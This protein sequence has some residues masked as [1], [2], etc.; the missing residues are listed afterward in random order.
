M[1]QRTSAVFLMH[2]VQDVNV[3]RPLI[4]MAA[5]DFAFDTLMLVSAGFYGRD[6]FGIWRAELAQ[7]SSEIGASMATF[8]ADW[9]AHRRL[10]GRGLIISAS[11]SSLPN[12]AVTHNV[13]RHAPAS[14]L[15]VTIQHGLECVGIRHSVDHDRAHG[16]TVS[17]G[18]DIICAWSAPANLPSL[19][20][21]QRGKVIV[22]GPTSVLQ[23]HGGEVSREVNAPGL[24]CENLHSVRMGGAGHVR[25]EFVEAFQQFARTMADRRTEVA[26]RPHPGGQYALKHK[27]P[28]PQNVQIRN[29]PLYRLDLRE[30]SYGISAPSSV[31]FDMV[32][33]GLPT[34]VWHD[35]TDDIDASAYDGLPTVSSADE[36]L[37]F[38]ATAQRDPN[39]FQRRQA[40]FLEKQEIP[41][42]PQ[43]VFSRYAKLFQSVDR[44][45][46][47]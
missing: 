27:L 8:D 21:S 3:L 39:A 10:T 7:I 43:E 25:Q 24:V 44:D 2:L 45:A 34:A 22:T 28:L 33:A 9:E 37:E 32:L 20:S 12:H 38:A 14:Y 4:Y 41:L 26:V 16:R 23:M 47:L 11:E 1:G 17:F 5:R 30:F 42:Q 15:R 29:E 35:S 36:W 6:H 40:A 19:A 46:A 13:F 31:L 18:A